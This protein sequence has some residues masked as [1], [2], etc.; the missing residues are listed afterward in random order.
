MKK[1][2]LLIFLLLSLSGCVNINNSEI[3]DIIYEA[4]KSDLK[5]IN[6]YRTGFKYYLPVNLNVKSTSRFNK[7]LFDGVYN[8][9]LFV[10]MISYYN[11]VK[12][13]YKV[14][15]TSYLSLNINNK[16]KIGYLEINKRND[17]YLIE[18]MYNYAKIEVIVDENDIK[19]A[20]SNSIVILSSIV[21]NKEM[22]ASMQDHSLMCN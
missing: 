12:F 2:V 18:I 13:N 3:K 8:Y 7:V 1:I 14:N 5:L 9:Y 10:D 6:T 11:D 17:K 16:E 4:Q 21:F 22:I 20:I 19:G 15:D